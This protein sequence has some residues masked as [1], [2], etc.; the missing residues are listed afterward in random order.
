MPAPTAIIETGHMQ[1][2]N[3]LKQLK[4]QIVGIEMHLKLIESDLIAIEGDIAFLEDYASVLKENISVLKSDKIIAMASEYKKAVV[5]LKQA[6]ENLK[7]YRAMKSQLNANYEKHLSLKE[8]SL[9]EYEE[10]KKQIDS[11]KV[12]LLFDPSKRKK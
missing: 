4:D 1:E 5:E 3:R 11:R 7:H 12:L 2:I 6:E 10:L 8:K 9:F